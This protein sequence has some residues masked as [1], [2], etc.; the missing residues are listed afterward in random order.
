MTLYLAHYESSNFLF[1]GVDKTEESAKAALL[2][3]IKHHCRQTGARINDFF[4]PDEIFIRKLTAGSTW[5][6]RDEL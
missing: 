5:R 2:R 3:A 6:N 1:E 4:Y